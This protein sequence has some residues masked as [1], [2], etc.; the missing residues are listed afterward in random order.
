[1]LIVLALLLLAAAGAAVYVIAMDGTGEVPLDS[2]GLDT[3]IPVWGV[4]AAGAATMLVLLAAV[5]AL[6]AGARAIRSRRTEIRYLRQQ[7][8][9]QELTE[10]RTTSSSGTG[11]MPTAGTATD[12]DAGRDT[13]HGR[14][15]RWRRHRAD[16]KPPAEATH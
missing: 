15:S 12:A 1:M 5:A 3:E 11:G 7:V 10:D 14:L 4:F 8:A 6:A 2:L 16:E 13:G 9:S